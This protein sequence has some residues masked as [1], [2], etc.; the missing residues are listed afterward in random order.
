VRLT[1][2]DVSMIATFSAAY[3]VLSLVPVSPFIGGPSIL[4]LN[5]II[6]PL[7]AILL[8]PVQA[9]LTAFMGSLVVFFVFP[10]ALA[11]I[12]G[13]TMLLMP[14][15]GSTVGSV[16]ARAKSKILRTLAL[17]YYAFMILLFVIR[18]PQVPYW[19]IPHTAALVVALFARRIAEPKL[20]VFALAFTATMAEQACMMV[21]ASW[22]LML[23]WQVFAIAFPLML[24]ER[25]L[26]TLGGGFLAF[27]VK[28]YIPER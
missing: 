7:I 26:A 18:I 24:Y 16:V 12:F 9:F 3:V 11:N 2:R 1:S 27:C 4:S 20:K 8:P 22:Y 21:L 23:P 6:V 17:A 5:L 28:K 25:V 14:I 10:A 13:P 15:A 19:V